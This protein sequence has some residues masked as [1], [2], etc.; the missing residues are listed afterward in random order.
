MKKKRIGGENPLCAAFGPRDQIL[1]TPDPWVNIWYKLDVL[2]LFNNDLR[3]I[4]TVLLGV[5]LFLWWHSASLVCFRLFLIKI[6]Q[7]LWVW[8]W[9]DLRRAERRRAVSLRAERRHQLDGRDEEE[10]TRRRHS[11]HSFTASPFCRRHLLEKTLLFY[12][13]YNQSFLPWSWRPP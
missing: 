6:P 3:A 13:T 5:R 7:W 10:R 4:T 2:T 12:R 1:D 8:C 9:E 11:D